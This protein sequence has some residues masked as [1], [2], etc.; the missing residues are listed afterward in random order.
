MDSQKLRA[1]IDSSPLGASVYSMTRNCRIFS[2][3]RAVELFGAASEAELNDFPAS[4]TFL[5]PEQGQ[6][7]VSEFVESLEGSRQEIRRRLDGSLWLSM[8][9]RQR[10]MIEDE[11]VYL[12][13]FDDITEREATQERFRRVFNIPTIPMALYYTADK[14]WIDVNDAFV[15]LFGYERDELD[16]MTWVD[17]THPDDVQRNLAAFDAATRDKSTTSYTLAKRFVHKN[18]AHIHAR[19][20]T[21]HIRGIDDKPD[22][23]VLVV[24]D[25]TDDVEK[26]KL[27]E[28][29]REELEANVV[30]LEET[31]SAL[32]KSTRKLELMNASEARLRALADAANTSKSQFL[33]TVSHEIRTPMTGIMGYADMLLDENLPDAAQDMVGR[34][35]LS[36]TSLLTV[37]NDVLDISK[38]DAGKLEIEFVNFNPSR[39]A[40]D[41]VQSVYQ[42]SMPDKRA[43]VSVDVQIADDF[44][45]AVS[46]DPTRLRQVLINLFG[47]AVKFTEQG[48]VTM[49]C[50]LGD[51]PSIMTFEIVDT[52][53][54]IDAD[55]QGKLFGDFVQADSSI[56]RKYHGTGLGLSICRRLIHLM[57]GDIGVESVPGKGSTFWFTLPFAPVAPGAELVNETALVRR[58]YTAARELHILVAEDNEIN[59]EIISNILGKI[60]HRYI[61]AADGNEAVEAVEAVDFDLVLMDVRMPEL[62][63]PDATRQ[64]RK[65]PGA[66]SRVPVI[67]L[68]ADA[69]MENRQS[70]FDAGMNDFVAKPINV[71]QLAAAMNKVLGETVNTAIDD[72]R[73]AAGGNGPGSDDILAQPGLPPEIAA[74]ILAKFAAK[75]ADADAHLTSLL[76]TGDTDAAVTFLHDMRGIAG[77]L[78]LR[79]VNATA[80]AL[81]LALTGGD[82]EAAQTA[83]EALAA[84]L[85]AALNGIANMTARSAAGSSWR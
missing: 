38:L 45:E 31:Q 51:T 25:M 73:S 65:L 68:T 13:W 82:I 27:L 23:V 6:V 16:H 47:N 50:G 80:D 14:R 54:G 85:D 11:D 48:S 66:K 67:A 28:Q 72:E 77:T 32:L 64:I 43:A 74:P 26:E 2:N 63:G 1:I 9:T 29:R 17:L 22:Y 78:G 44:P 61:I 21:E 49:R 53:I 5:D 37:I 46:T 34:I 36:T 58:T 41:V 56:S 15:T 42:S 10:M 20:H 24:H 35:K 79:R 3:Q 75:Y 84:A 59:Q 19:I 81:E 76:D 55:T 39:I 62:S 70:Y 60:G 33:A 30:S 52:G 40:N 18:G 71:D 12:I 4:E 7:V 83:L 57:G 69:V 8:T